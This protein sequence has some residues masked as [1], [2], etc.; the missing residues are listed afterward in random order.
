MTETEFKPAKRQCKT[1]GK[2]KP[3]VEFTFWT[4]KRDGKRIPRNECKACANKRDKRLVGRPRKRKGKG[5]KQ[6]QIM[7]A[8]PKDEHGRPLPYWKWTEEQS[9]AYDAARGE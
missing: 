4:R 8:L 6:G 5:H 1:C 3:T 7:R 9:R 2:T